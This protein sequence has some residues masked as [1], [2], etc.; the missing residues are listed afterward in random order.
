MK[1]KPI[2]MAIL[3]ELHMENKFVSLKFLIL[4]HDITNKFYSKK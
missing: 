2:I 3:E 4:L 1:L